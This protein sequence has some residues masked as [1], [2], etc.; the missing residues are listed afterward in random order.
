[1][2]QN[3]RMHIARASRRGFSLIE[4][5]VVVALITLL[6]TMMMPSYRKIKE[7][8][9]A[10]VCMRNVGAIGQATQNY[11]AENEGT[12]PAGGNWWAAFGYWEKSINL[13]AIKGPRNMDWLCSVAP[14]LTG[15]FDSPWNIA[16]D[17]LRDQ[18]DV[19]RCPLMYS[20][21]QDASMYG[22]QDQDE[23]D[24]PRN[25]KNI[26]YDYAVPKGKVLF[27]G[28]K[29]A[30]IAE[31]RYQASKNNPTFRIGSKTY[32][33]MKEINQPLQTDQVVAGADRVAMLFEGQ[34]N[35]GGLAFGSAH[36]NSF[37]DLPT[38]L[39]TDMDWVAP[40]R[41]HRIQSEPTQVVNGYDIPISGG[42][43]VL[44]ID[45]H[46]SY[47]PQRTMTW[48]AANRRQ[49]MN[50]Y[51]DENFNEV[52][53]FNEAYYD[54]LWGDEADHHYDD[55]EPIQT[56]NVYQ[57][58]KFNIEKSEVHKNDA[59]MDYLNG[60]ADGEDLFGD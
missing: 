1:M 41:H 19:V 10:Q 13:N 52:S 34:D 53:S 4:L 37:D 54:P 5:M 8:A 29:G 51:F 45:G 56:L 47:R 15:E 31:I 42:G 60:K 28:P 40:R 9:A 7:N 20:D 59:V 39:I 33:G 35:L 14:Y 55:P 11:V 49:L 2:S 30:S 50:T 3:P 57:P 27:N 18:L 17:E 16:A 12:L 24:D 22:T 46:A 32:R 48:M 36:K 23:W 26:S 44:F 38:S 43:N 21:P 25:I 6:M 58:A